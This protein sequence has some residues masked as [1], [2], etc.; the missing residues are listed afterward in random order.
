MTTTPRIGPVPATAPKPAVDA[1]AAPDEATTAGALT[2]VGRPSDR[3][4]EPAATVTAYRDGPLIVRGDFELRNADGEPIET[5]RRVIALCR[6]GRSGRK[7]LCDGSHTAN[8][9]R[10]D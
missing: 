8:G 9:W 7:P 1:S 6:C 3:R 4:S 2:S 5:A 10:C